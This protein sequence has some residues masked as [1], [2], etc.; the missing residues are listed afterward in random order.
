MKKG[1]LFLGQGVGAIAVALAV[2]APWL[3][4]AYDL[5]LL[6]RFLALSLTAMGL[7]LL[8][9]EGGILS[10]GQGVFFGLGGYA[11]AMHL[12]LADL[13]A[14]EIPDFMVWSGLTALPW[15]WALFKSAVLSILMV[16]LLPAAIAALFGWAIFRRRISG[17]Y[18]AL[19][20]QA[21]A[22]AFATLLISQQGK[23]GGFN[24]L[25]DYHTLLGFN[26]NLPSTTTGL[27][28]LTL[29]LV[30]AAFFG[31]RWLLG[32][33]FGKL[34][35]ASRDGSNRLRFLGYD[36]TPYKVVA[37]TGAAMLTGV[38]GALFTLHAG[39]ISPAL[40]SVVPSIEMVIWVAIG[41]RDSIAGAL[42]GTLLVNFAK[43]KISTAFPEL[44]LYGLGLLFILSV[45]ALP[46]GLA[47]LVGPDH[48]FKPEKLGDMF[49][50]WR[51]GKAANATAPKPTPLAEEIAA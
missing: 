38:S 26:L 35:R 50:R 9:G 15:W 20:T 22:L 19:I 18:F 45:T 4:S 21:L 28:F 7:V 44:W 8:W 48:P 29:F 2:A 36:P 6:A 3:L 30:V 14:G 51:R 46:K 39:V 16:F 40:V 37:F 11:L 27:Y 10:L 23:T 13:G 32:S 42:A 25:T 43:D 12:K 17:V 34:L 41:G 31:L 33:R 24:G 1:I 47:G 5:N 49:A